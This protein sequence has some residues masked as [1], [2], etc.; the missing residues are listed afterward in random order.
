MMSALALARF[1]AAHLPGG[2]DG[3][4]LLSQETIKKATQISSKIVSPTGT[5]VFGLGYVLGSQGCVFGDRPTMFGHGG[6]GGTIG[7]A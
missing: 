3:V 1:Y 5:T 7:F 6:Y 4:S 2:I